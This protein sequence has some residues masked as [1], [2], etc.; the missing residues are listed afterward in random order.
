MADISYRDAAAAYEACDM[1]IEDAETSKINLPRVILDALP[2]L[3]S[4]QAMQLAREYRED[5]GE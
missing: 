5:N 1:A 2:H 3:G 4:D